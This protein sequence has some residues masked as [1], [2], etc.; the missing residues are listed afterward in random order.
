MS[1]IVIYV[2][3]ISIL[4]SMSFIQPYLTDQ[5]VE[6]WTLSYSSNCSAITLLDSSNRS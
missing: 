2:T 6:Q 5:T 4:P 1:F 3:F